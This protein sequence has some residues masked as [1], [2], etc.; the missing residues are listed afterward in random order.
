[1]LSFNHQENSMKLLSV[2]VLF[3]SVSAF[4]Q[5]GQPAAAAP[6]ATGM[7]AS[8]PATEAPKMEKK[9]KHGKKGHAGKK[10]ADKAAE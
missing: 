2:L 3:A 4:A 6:E 7:A 1:M 5:N 9:K 8:A 10:H